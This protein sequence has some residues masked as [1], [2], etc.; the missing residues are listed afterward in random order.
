MATED[1]STPK[2]LTAPEAAQPQGSEP[3]APAMPSL[4]PAVLEHIRQFDLAPGECRL[5]DPI[6]PSLG[7]PYLNPPRPRACSI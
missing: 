1:A 2:P 5:L 3:P 4:P 7:L 6:D